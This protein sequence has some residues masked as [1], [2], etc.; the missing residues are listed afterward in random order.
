MLDHRIRGSR[1]LM[2][3]I[4]RDL[5]VALPYLATPGEERRK[6]RNFILVCA[7]LVAAFACAIAAAVYLGI[8]VDFSWFDRSWMDVFN[9]STA[10]TVFARRLTRR[11]A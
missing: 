6:R 5:I 9:S 11:P 2:D 7:V 3:I 4:D 8:S 10:V 1:E